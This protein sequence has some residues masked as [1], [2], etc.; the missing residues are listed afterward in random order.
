M[1]RLALAYGIHQMRRRV[2]RRGPAVR[3]LLAVYSEDRLLP[4]TPEERAVLP[5]MSR[6]INCGLCAYVAQSHGSPPVSDL[7]SAYLRSYPLLANAGRD[8]GGGL[9]N[10]QEAAAACPTG[11]PLPEV[12]AM[13]LRLS[14]R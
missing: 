5:A 7:A 9:S 10:L 11:V 14:G 6:C 2:R 4:I 1:G 12:A 3:R 13:I 8:L